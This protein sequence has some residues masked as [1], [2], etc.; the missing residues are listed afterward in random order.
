MWMMILSKTSG[1]PLLYSKH[2]LSV[3]AAG[4][5]WM[6]EMFPGVSSQPT[7]DTQWIQWNNRTP[8]VNLTVCPTHAITDSWKIFV[9]LFSLDSNS[10]HV[11]ACLSS[12]TFIF[13]ISLALPEAWLLVKYD[14]DGIS[15]NMIDFVACRLFHFLLDH[16]TLYELSYCI[17]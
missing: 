5:H 11:L 13:S 4:A 9:S 16:T 6:R 10:I 8:T 7:M 15:E 2:V 14:M 1:P 12:H 17:V 3:V